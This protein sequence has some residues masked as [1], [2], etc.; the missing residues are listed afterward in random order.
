[1]LLLPAKANCGSMNLR[2]SVPEYLTT[3]KNTIIQV[4]FTTVF[5]YIFINIYRPF[6][7]D[8]WYKI[9]G[10][11]LLVASAVVVVAGMFVV[12]L[13]RILF[14][15]LKKTHEITYALYIW[16]IV[17][18]IFFMGVF[19]TSLEIWILNDERP[20]ISLLFNSIQNTALILLIPYTISFLFFSWSDIKKRLEQTVSQFKEPTELFIPFRDEKG[21]LKITI[22][23]SDVLYLESNDNYVNIHY[24]DREKR[25]VYMIRSSLK[26]YERELK[27]YPIWRNHRKYS[28]NIQNIKMMVKAPKGYELVM[29]S[30]GQE[31]IP[32]SRSYEKKIMQ[33]LHIK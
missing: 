8:D 27:D 10:W 25:K 9:S 4:A 13:S 5:A 32:V 30:W 12:L 20:P 17:A 22:K 15:Q 14:F 3:R 29:N 31:Q 26:Q 21:N 24:S 6:G 7:Y 19:Y 28:V 2:Q 23:S 18:E 16:F 33:L 11:E 1:M